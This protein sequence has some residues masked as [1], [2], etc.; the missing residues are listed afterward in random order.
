MLQ[1][2]KTKLCPGMTFLFSIWSSMDVTSSDQLLVRVKIGTKYCIRVIHRL[3]GNQINEIASKCDHYKVCV[4][5]HPRDEDI[6][7]ENCFSCGEIHTY[8]VHTAKSIS[9]H[10]GPEIRIMCCGPAGSLLAVDKKLN[11]LL[12]LDWPNVQSHEPQVICRVNV[13]ANNKGFLG[14]CYVECQNILICTSRDPVSD[15]DYEIS[16]VKLEDGTILW[17]LFGPVDGIIIKPLCIACDQEGNAYVT[18][19]ATN[20]ILKIDSLTGQVLGVLLFE[21]EAKKAKV[22]SICWSNTG[23]KC[24][25]L[26]TIKI[27]F[28]NTM[29]EVFRRRL[30]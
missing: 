14:F 21:D 12:K 30:P 9:V 6:V 24:R 7:L 8:N 4:N 18:D 17:R 16:A 19:K 5:K 11:G 10:K 15:A 3:T 1:I 13:P 26:T 22:M 20:R 29:Y 27:T 2:K 28:V 23:N 25:M